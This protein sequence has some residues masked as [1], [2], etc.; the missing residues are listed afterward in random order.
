MNPK[1][2]QKASSVYEQ[3]RVLAEES[4]KESYREKRR[5]IAKVAAEVF[6]KLGFRGTSLK[7]VAEALGMS[8]SALYYYI[9][10]KRELFDE[11][12]REAIETN[13]AKAEVICAGG[14][15]AVEKI[16]CLTIDLMRSCGTHFPLLY[17]FL[18][19]N[20]SHVETR[21]TEWSRRVRE[22]NRR[23]EG[24][25]ISVID[26]GI[27][28]GTLRPVASPRVIAYGIFGMICWTSRWFNPHTSLESAEVIGAAFAEMA[29][30]GIR[31]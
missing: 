28:N 22:L 29:L 13:V 27:K 25:V 24:L 7:A 3:R 20:L 4:G 11:L 23:Y 2:K 10:N 26:E 15:S 5:E 8:R 16:R 12:V 6:N 31:I 17:I 19:E 1:N 9:P 18:R 21:R 30:S 14:E